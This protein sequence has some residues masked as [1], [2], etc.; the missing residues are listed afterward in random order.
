MLTIMNEIYYSLD[1][2]VYLIRCFLTFLCSSEL[3]FWK[4]FLTQ[5]MK[6]SWVFFFYKSQLNLYQL[7]CFSYTDSIFIIPLIITFRNTKIFSTVFR[8]V[9]KKMWILSTS[10]KINI[11][12]TRNWLSTIFFDHMNITYLMGVI[13]ILWNSI[14]LS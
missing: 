8:H 11:D 4:H 10:L 1:I 12:I 6:N 14:K 5:L 3:R 2:G 9:S 7:S 13:I